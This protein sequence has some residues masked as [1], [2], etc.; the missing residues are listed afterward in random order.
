[1]H[2]YI[3]SFSS[4]HPMASAILLQPRMSP[5]HYPD[6]TFWDTACGWNCS[7]NNP[8][9]DTATFPPRR[10]TPFTGATSRRYNEG[11]VVGLSRA[12]GIPGYVPEILDEGHVWVNLS[13]LRSTARSRITVCGCRFPRTSSIYKRRE[14]QQPFLISFFRFKFLSSYSLTFQSMSI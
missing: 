7:Q 9:L 8:N 13:L 4:Y 3:V 12:S 1:M 5:F 10:S 6:R 2:R 14:S 11:V